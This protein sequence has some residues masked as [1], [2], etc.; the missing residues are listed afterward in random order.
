MEKELIY[1]HNSGDYLYDAYLYGSIEN[2]YVNNGDLEIIE[3]ETQIKHIFIVS[4]TLE[5]IDSF[6]IE[7]I[8]ELNGNISH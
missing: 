2:D 7:K 3:R 1:T 8:I 4:G 6:T 5:T